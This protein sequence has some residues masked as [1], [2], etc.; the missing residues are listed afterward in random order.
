MCTEF[1]LECAARLLRLGKKRRANNNLRFN[2][3]FMVIFALTIAATNAGVLPLAAAPA[4]L[5]APAVAPVA[6]AAY[7]VA[8][9]ASS[10]SAH[11]INHA[12]AA[13]VVASAPVVAPAPLVAPA[14]VVPAAQ[15]VAA[16][17]PYFSRYVSSYPYYL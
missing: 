4:A 11:S 16:P 10:Y 17:S 2:S 7:A 6:S 12:V 9:Y 5:V 8:P 1:Q 13:P 15:Y 3:K 14:P